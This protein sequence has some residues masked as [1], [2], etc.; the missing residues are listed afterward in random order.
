MPAHSLY[1]QESDHYRAVTASLLPFTELILQPFLKSRC[2]EP[3]FSAPEIKQ[4]LRNRTHKK[5]Y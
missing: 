5:R 2:G 3:F 4:K 1:S